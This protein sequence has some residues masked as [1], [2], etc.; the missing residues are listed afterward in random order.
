M[1]TK[2]ASAAAPKKQVLG[3]N[4]RKWLKAL[5]SGKFKQTRQGHLHDNKGFCC[6]GVAC[7]LF[8]TPT[9]KITVDFLSDDNEVAYAGKDDY[10]PSYVIDALDLYSAQGSPK[11]GDV[12][13]E[14]AILND[15][16]GLGNA[17]K[18][19]FKQIATIVERDPSVYFR[20][21]K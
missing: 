7:V 6:L 20:S 19:T 2:K 4:Q 1:P 9:T 21:P 3:P 12:A 5:R 8:K 18:K 17:D 16:S 13:S 14:L 15:G 11:D 10:A